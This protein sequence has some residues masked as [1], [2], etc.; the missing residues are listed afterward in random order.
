MTMKNATLI[1]TK[2]NETARVRV[3]QK[4]TPPGCINFQSHLGTLSIS[5]SGLAFSKVRHLLI[6]VVFNQKINACPSLVGIDARAAEEIQ[7]RMT[8]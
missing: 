8:A 5:L 6:V 4:A 1:N 3:M 2:I 7:G